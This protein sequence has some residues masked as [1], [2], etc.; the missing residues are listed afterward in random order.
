MC[1]AIWD[2]VRDQFLYCIQQNPSVFN[3]DLSSG[4]WI[5]GTVN[6]GGFLSFAVHIILL[7]DFMAVLAFTF[8]P[9]KAITKI[10]VYLLSSFQKCVVVVFSC[11]TLAFVTYCLEN[12]LILW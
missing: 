4:L 12:L 11:M 2:A 9:S 7:L 10:Y 6:S 8:L 5:A 1:L 3:S